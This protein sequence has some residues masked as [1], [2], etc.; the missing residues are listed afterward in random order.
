[1]ATEDSGTYQ[2]TAVDDRGRSA[3]RTVRVVVVVQDEDTVAS[4]AN[5]TLMRIMIF[6]AISFGR[7]IVN[8]S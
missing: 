2:C 8:I 7:K 3:K 1:M 6:L 5:N 4:A